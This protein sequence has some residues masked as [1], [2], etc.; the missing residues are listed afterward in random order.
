MVCNPRGNPVGVKG[1]LP[2]AFSLAMLLPAWAGVAA[3]A[4][5][6]S[7]AAPASPREGDNLTKEQAAA[8][9]AS[10]AKT[11]DDLESRTQLLAYYFSP[12]SQPIGTEARILARR[13]H[14][15]WL[16]QNHPDLP[17]LMEP[18]ASLDPT[19]QSLAD[20]EGYGL[21]K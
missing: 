9:E 11:P 3:Q 7:Q 19:S 14:I 8:L 4:P 10:L 5:A 18:Q 17:L 1:I 16:I 2:L 21:A 15:L 12:A 13:C 6:S 20:A